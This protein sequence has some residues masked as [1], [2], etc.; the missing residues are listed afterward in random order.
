MGVKGLKKN[1]V[2]RHVTRPSP[3]HDN[4]NH[5]QDNTRDRHVNTFTLIGSQLVVLLLRALWPL[6]T[7]AQFFHFV[8]EEKKDD[9]KAKAFY[10]WATTGI[11]VKN[12]IQ[13][14]SEELLYSHQVICVITH[15]VA[16]DELARNWSIL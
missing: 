11:P 10:D 13:I 6:G 14:C 5:H 4:V 3:V 7:I 9:K 16:I 8:A 12:K 2:V 15:N 1:L